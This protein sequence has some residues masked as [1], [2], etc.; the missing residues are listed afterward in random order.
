[1]ASS[2]ADPPRREAVVE[3]SWTWPGGAPVSI[4]GRE[5]NQSHAGEG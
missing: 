4:P 1:M 3:V 2:L 5:C